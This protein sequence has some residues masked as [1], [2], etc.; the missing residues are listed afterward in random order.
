M[1]C[2]ESKSEEKALSLIAMYHNCFAKIVYTLHPTNIPGEIRGKAANVGWAAARL[3]EDESTPVSSVSSND[4][5]LSDY[6]RKLNSKVN[7]SNQLEYQDYLAKN[8]TFPSHYRNN[9]LKQ[10]RRH[11]E[12][13]REILTVMDSD[14]C[15]AEDYFLSVAVKYCLASYEMKEVMMFAPCTVFDR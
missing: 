2:S 11:Q 9:H 14:T 15:F 8:Q 7:P 5:S 3:D 12:R 10:K 4:A 1:E 6:S 13:I